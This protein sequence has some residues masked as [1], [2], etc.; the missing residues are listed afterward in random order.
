[1]SARRGRRGARRD[2]MTVIELMVAIIL[3]GVGMLGLAG[4]SVTV[5]KQQRG[6][7]LQETAALVVQS[8]LDSLASIQCTMLA[9]SGSQTGTATTMKVTERW[10]ITDGNDIKTIVDT[11][12][13][14]GR[15][16]PLVYKSVIPCRD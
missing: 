3:L 12:K 8:R 4:L 13:F 5:A 2:G 11:V 9:P 1:M 7:S 16:K 10:I 14:A 15:V 6:G